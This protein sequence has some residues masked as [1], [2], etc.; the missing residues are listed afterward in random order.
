VELTK[1]DWIDDILTKLKWLEDIR[2]PWEAEWQEI[3]DYVHPK[4]ANFDW[5]KDRFGER[6]GTKIYDSMA[7]DSNELRAEGLQGYVTSAA[8]AWFRLG[9]E[10]ED[11]GKL[12]G[13]KAWIEE[14]E[15]KFYSIFRRSNFYEAIFNMFLDYGAFGT[16]VMYIELDPKTGKVV[17]STR[18]LKEIYIEEDKHQRADT[19]YRRSYMSARDL[20]KTF[21]EDKFE[22]GWLERAESRPF[23]QHL[24]LHATFPRED[25]DFYKIDQLNKPVASI[26]ILEKGK[27]LLREGGYDDNPYIV[28]RDG[29]NPDE[30]YG[31]GVSHSALPEILQSQEI[32]R[33][34]M[35]GRQK[36]VDPA[37]TYPAELMGTLDLDPGGENPLSPGAGEVK[38]INQ[39]QFYPA[40]TEQQ[41]QIWKRIRDKYNVDFWLMLTQMIG[42]NIT[43]TQ[44]MEMSAEKAAVLG[45]LLGL[46]NDQLLDPLFDRVFSIAYKAGMFPVPPESLI[47]TQAEIKVDYIG[48]LAQKQKQFHAVF[49]LNQALQQYAPLTEL[50]PETKDVLDWDE[51]AIHILESGGAPAKTVRDRKTIKKIRDGRA[52]AQQE[53]LQMQQGQHLADLYNKTQKAPEEGS[54]AEAIEGAL[55]GQ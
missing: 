47:S 41:E 38:A 51:A 15:K 20:I 54:G 7:Q 39:S 14:V 18:H 13:A 3:A 17:F 22:E 50:A 53:V 37:V 42:Q 49:G 23:E 30:V 44:V 4:R 45:T 35:R 11:I 21:G 43:A 52:K 5:D 16:A 29:K 25:R 8:S 31:L 1:T 9:F 55:S 33:D 6:I 10:D 28:L 24:V 19:I 36:A 2:K 26:Y 34:T 40:G 12:P 48:P 27:I 32:T 46:I